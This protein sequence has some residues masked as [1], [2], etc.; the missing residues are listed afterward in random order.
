MFQSQVI[1]KITTHVMFS[2][3]FPKNHTAF[4]IM[5]R[6]AVD[7]ETVTNDMTLYMH[8]ACWISKASDIHSDYITLVT[9]LQLEWSCEHVSALLYI[10][11][12]CIVV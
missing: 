7:P 8:F 1:E 3:F 2:T 4:E 12:A 10:Y 5:W 11:I 9:I 6:N